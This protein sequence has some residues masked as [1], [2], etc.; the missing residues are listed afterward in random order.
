MHSLF[1]TSLTATVAS[2][3]VSHVPSGTVVYP[4]LVAQLTQEVPSTMYPF[5]HWA[6]PFVISILFVLEVHTFLSE[7]LSKRF[8]L[9]AQ[10]LHV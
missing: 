8:S 6:I 1:V 7:G 10:A 9:D 4:P 3:S 2:Q 5:E